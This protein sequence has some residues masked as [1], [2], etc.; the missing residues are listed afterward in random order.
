MARRVMEKN[1]TVWHDTARQCVAL[2]VAPGPSVTF[3]D[4]QP[5]GDVMWRDVT[6][7]HVV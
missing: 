2:Y 3:H 1:S 7:R 6:R 4:G 5:D